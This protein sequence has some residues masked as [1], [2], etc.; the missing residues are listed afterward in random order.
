MNLGDF[1][2]CV[3]QNRWSSNEKQKTWK[4]YYEIENVGS[5]GWKSISFPVKYLHR[6]FYIQSPANQNNANA[7]YFCKKL[8]FHIFGEPRND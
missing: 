3:E 6:G 7:Q 8:N 4:T 1:V 2:H 5:V